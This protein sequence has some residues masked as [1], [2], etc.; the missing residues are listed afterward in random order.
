MERLTHQISTNNMFKIKKFIFLLIFIFSQGG[1]HSLENSIIYKV[2]ND[3]ITAYDLKKEL[4]Y[5]ISLNPK[6]KALKEKEIV[7]LAHQSAIKEKIKKIELE[8]NYSLGETLTN[9]SLNEILKNLYQNI[10]IKDENEFKKYLVQ[11]DI[12]IEWVKEKLEIESLWNMLIY[13]KYKEQVFIDEDKIRNE[14]NKEVKLKKDQ[15]RIFFSEILIKIINDQDQGK[16]IDT[17]KK[18]I[19]EIGFNNTANIYSVSSTANKGGKIGWVNKNSL[20][21]VIL[22]R[23]NYLKKGQHSK[24]I[25]LSSGY[26]ILKIEDVQIVD[27]KID[28]KKALNNR[29]N[30]ERDRQLDLQSNIFFN[31]I[32]KQM[33]ID[34]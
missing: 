20:S 32:K 15:S 16:L 1:A 18:S 3:I 11:F 9:K 12:S 7:K 2:N 14:L 5:L 23:I 27:V 31:R 24:P 30:N 13:D 21:P 6:L 17:V 4:R 25:K 10:G 28:F 19:E 26:L 34:G 29:I 22:K 33:K 8:K